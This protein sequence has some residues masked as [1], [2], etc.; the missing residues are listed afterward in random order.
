MR[1]ALVLLIRIGIV[2]LIGVAA[3]P[4]VLPLRAQEK[5]RVFIA[6]NAIRRTQGYKSPS[7]DERTTTVE[8]RTIEMSRDFSESCKEVTVSAERRKADY[9]VRLNWKIG[10]S[11]IGVYRTNGDL[12]G[13]ADKS[14]IN[15]SVKAACELIKRDLPQT[16]AKTEEK[17]DPAPTK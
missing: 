8:D 2:M 9:I 10:R 4:L 1:I 17:P 16:A 11:Q 12:V 7:Y 5:R 3:L 6:P 14:S 15:G 13:V